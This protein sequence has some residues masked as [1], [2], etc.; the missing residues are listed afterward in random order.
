[1][2]IRK[3]TSTDSAD[4]LQLLKIKAEFDRSMGGSDGQIT[5]S[6]EK[7]IS[8][9]FRKIPFAYVLLVEEKSDIQGFAFYHYRYSSFSG[10]PSIWL[11]D[12]LI[13]KEHRSKKLGFYLMQS[14]QL[15]GKKINASHIAWTAS[16]NNEKGLQFYK[17]L[18]A[19]V[20][21]IINGRPFFR[22][23]VSA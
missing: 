5:S 14:L 15:E 8:T 9:L 1:M 6:E 17:R 10:V 7:I 12:L 11:D 2:N 21:K 22:W 19:K 13:L 23:E 20:D 4:I 3:A 16:P 18:G